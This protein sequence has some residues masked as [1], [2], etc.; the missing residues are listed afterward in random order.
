MQFVLDLLVL[1]GSFVLAY[2]LRYEFVISQ[3]VLF[4]ALVQLPYVVLIQVV[5]LAL[6]GVYTFI[7][8]YVGMREVRSFFYAFFW[9]SLVLMALRFTLPDRFGDWRVPLSVILTGTTVGFLGV[10]GIRV[11]SAG[12]LG[13]GREDPSSPEVLFGGTHADALLRSGRRWCPCGA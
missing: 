7:W 13:G 3:K 5:A 12:P 9:S 2:L 4:D 8:R 1:T 11:A 10:L 6:A